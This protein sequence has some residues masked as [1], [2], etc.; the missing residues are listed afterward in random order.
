MTRYLI[1]IKADFNIL[2]SRNIPDIL[3]KAI[4][5]IYTQHEILNVTPNYQNWLKLITEFSV[6]P[7]SPILFNIY[8]D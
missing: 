2:K 4:V 6:F 8:L 3:L 5:K 1:S 7:P